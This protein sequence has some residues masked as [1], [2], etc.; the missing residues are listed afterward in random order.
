[1]ELVTLLGF[2]LDIFPLHE[3]DGMYW[4]LQFYLKTRGSHIERMLSFAKNESKTLSL[5][6]FHLLEAMAMQDLATALVYL[7]A[8]LGRFG[9]LGR[10]KD[11]L[12]DEAFR[13]EGRMKPFLSMGVPE[14]VPYEF[15]RQMVDNVDLDVRL[16]APPPPPP[17][18][19]N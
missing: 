8:A 19:I 17:Q 13:Y 9:L 2:E 4:Y 18:F 16:P 6:N 5:L 7:Y 15:F 1:M 14:V 11:P 3:F 12:G 10:P